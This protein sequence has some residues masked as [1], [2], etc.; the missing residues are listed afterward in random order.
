[1][2]GG[3]LNGWQRLW[4][5]ATVLWLAWVAFYTFQKF[6]TQRQQFSFWAESMEFRVRM[7]T[8]N[9]PQRAEARGVAHDLRLML[10]DEEFINTLP[11]RLPS[12]DFSNTL[13]LYKSDRASLRQQQ[14]GW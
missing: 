9:L 13:G 3:R 2:T 10:S 12:I 4:V 8:E 11:E 7:A 5:I 14:L 1:M 6:P